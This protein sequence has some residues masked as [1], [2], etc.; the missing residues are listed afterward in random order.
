MKRGPGV[1]V[2][3]KTIRLK[4]KHVESKISFFLSGNANI[5]TQPVKID[6]YKK[7]DSK[8][9]TIQIFNNDPQGLRKTKNEK[10]PTREIRGTS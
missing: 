9:K 5:K 3:R 6:S 7:L 4:S 10:P 1:V 8:Q 2:L